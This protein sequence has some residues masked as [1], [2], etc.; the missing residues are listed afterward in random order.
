[1][2]RVVTVAMVVAGLLVGLSFA[3]SATQAP[4]PEGTISILV[5]SNGKVVSVQGKAPYKNV[6]KQPVGTLSAGTAPLSILVFFNNPP[7]CV[8]VSNTGEWWC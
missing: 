2:R 7:G 1:M 6:G 3:I 8:Y 5:D 4:P